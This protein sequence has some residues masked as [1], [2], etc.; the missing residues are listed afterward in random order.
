M[1]GFFWAAARA[2]GFRGFSRPRGSLSR[3]AQVFH[4]GHVHSPDCVLA[5]AASARGSNWCRFPP[6]RQRLRVS[7]AVLA[8]PRST[9]C[10]AVSFTPCPGRASHCQRQC[11]GCGVQRLRLCAEST[12]AATLC[13]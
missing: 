9:G 12:S 4:G 3:P 6:T 13:S 7:R 10:A 11:C 5:S 2:R 8:S 1:A